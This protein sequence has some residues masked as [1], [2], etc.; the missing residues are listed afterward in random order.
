MPFS[1]PFAARL[2]QNTPT[3]NH[4]TEIRRQLKTAK[5]VRIAVAFVSETGVLAFV[6]ALQGAA[7]RD[8]KVQVFTSIERAV[9]TPKALYLLWQ[10]SR[11]LLNFEVF[12]IGK[13]DETAF[14]HSKIYYFA[15]SEKSATIIGSANLTQGGLVENTETSLVFE[16]EIASRL[17]TQIADFFADLQQIS[18]SASAALLNRY[19]VL[20]DETQGLPINFELTE[21][22][23]NSVFVRY[24]KNKPFENPKLRL[25]K[26]A[27]VA[28]LSVENEPVP[29]L[30][31]VYLGWL[32]LVH[33]PLVRF[34]QHHQALEAA[35]LWRAV[36]NENAKH[37]AIYAFEPLTFEQI[38][39]VLH[40]YQ[41]RRF[42]PVSDELFWLLRYE[43][44]LQPC[45]L[46]EL[47]PDYYALFCESISKLRKTY[48]CKTN[49]EVVQGLLALSIPFFRVSET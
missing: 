47:S 3:Q 12:W 30:V 18:R 8:V 33:R 21:A 25:V 40:L 1:S 43:L 41:P 20:F 46:S 27:L 29:P 45:L 13:A 44:G 14:F 7:K 9:S 11:Y 2:V 34:V 17:D 49:G 37:A 38:S 39:T 16:Q 15:A 4:L 35:T 28:W 24:F 23:R 6:E 19:A 32:H 42:A 10:A 26:Q 48:R 36:G 22:D 5:T 31:S